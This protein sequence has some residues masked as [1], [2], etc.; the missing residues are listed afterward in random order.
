MPISNVNGKT[1]YVITPTK[2]EA[3]KDSTGNSWATMYTRQRQMIWDQL[4]LNAA[5]EQELALKQRKLINDRIMNLEDTIGQLQRGELDAR[6]AIEMNNADNVTQIE[7]AKLQAAEVATSSRSSTGSGRGGGSGYGGTGSGPRLSDDEKKYASDVARLTEKPV[8]G[9]TV[10]GDASLA[11]DLAASFKKNMEERLQGSTGKN[12][13]DITGVKKEAAKVYATQL[14]NDALTAK[15]TETEANDLYNAFY[16]NLPAEYEE[17]SSADN[18]GTGT[19]GSGGGGGGIYASSS[20][21]R[22]ATPQSAIDAAR[23]GLTEVSPNAAAAI[24]GLQ[25]KVAMLEAQAG[26]IGSTQDTARQRFAQEVGGIWG[27]AERPNY[28]QSY[29]EPAGTVDRIGQLVD[30]YKVVA[31]KALSDAARKSN[32]PLGEIDDIE[33]TQAA[34]KMLREDIS[35]GREG[36]VRPV[37]EQEY[38][39]DLRERPSTSDTVAKLPERQP[40]PDMTME[41]PKPLEIYSPSY[42]PTIRAKQPEAPGTVFRSPDRND[43]ELR[44]RARISPLPPMVSP[45]EAKQEKL[46]PQTSTDRLRR[47]RV[48]ETLADILTADKV[49]DENPNIARQNKDTLVGKIA[50]MEKDPTKALIEIDRAYEGDEK[51]LKR[52]KNMYLAMYLAGEKNRA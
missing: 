38:M 40:K 30:S 8:F 6:K 14:Y 48:N 39:R 23:A 11:T 19:G 25:D 20:S 36:S 13:L 31:R 29:Q 15:R 18:T 7:K 45:G 5:N 35:K 37:A 43:E 50:R 1:V 4:A 22:K 34:M 16:N 27:F 51:A 46:E 24:T 28:M 12:V 47:Q 44:N 2:V 33:V 26:G 49:S 52:N 10:V 3:S 21:Y 41:E 42:E 32:R 17:S 9:Q